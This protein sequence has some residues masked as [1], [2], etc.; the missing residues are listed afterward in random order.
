MFIWLKGLFTSKKIYMEYYLVKEVKKYHGLCGTSYKKEYLVWEG[1][2][3]WDWFG[4]STTITSLYKK[5]Y[6]Q[7]DENTFNKLKEN[8]NGK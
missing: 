2:D 7:V 8:T 5:G 4:F 6:Y 1:G 3:S